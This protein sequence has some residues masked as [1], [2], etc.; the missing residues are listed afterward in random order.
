MSKKTILMIN[1]HEDDVLC[2]RKQVILGLEKE[3][4]RVVLLYPLGDRT[5]EITSENI[6]AEDIEMDRHG[7]NPFKDFGLLLRYVKAIKKHKP[8]V[9][10]LYTIKPN[11]YGGMAASFLKVPFVNNITGIGSSMHEKETLLEKFVTLLYKISLR[12]TTRVFFQNKENRE[13]FLEKKICT[14]Y[15]SSLIPGSGV[16]LNRFSYHPPKPSDKVVFN[17]IGRV[18]RTKGILEYVEAAGRIKENHPQCEFNILGFVENDETELIELLRTE[19]EKGHVLYRGPQSDVLPWIVASDAIILPSKYGEGMSN[20]LLETAAIGRALI[21]TAIP[22]CACLTENANGYV[23]KPGDT[24]GLVQCIE[25]F[26]ALPEEERTAMGVRSRELV[27]RSYSRERVVRAY[28]DTVNDLVKS[29][30]I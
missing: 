4:Y 30:T 25:Q 20:V 14:E 23:C 12:K 10:L 3:G 21:T 2:F 7:C 26:L 19:E 16:D 17:Y 6:I 8:S 15:N 9:V 18:M 5:A 11:I 27:E 28:V 1:V 22:G 24:D 29:D 13:L